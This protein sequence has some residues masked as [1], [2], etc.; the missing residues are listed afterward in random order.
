VNDIL[1]KNTER[2]RKILLSSGAGSHAMVPPGS[3]SD[4]YN[5]GEQQGAK[6]NISKGGVAPSDF[7][8]MAG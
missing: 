4:S 2:K 8:V 6:M 3:G 5:Y 1:N 7:S